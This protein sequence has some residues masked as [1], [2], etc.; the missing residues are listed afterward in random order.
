MNGISWSKVLHTGHKTHDKFHAPTNDPAS[1][2]PACAL[3][4]P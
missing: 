1:L 4:A 3:L 2:D